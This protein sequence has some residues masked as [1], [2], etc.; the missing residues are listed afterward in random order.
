MKSWRR[1]VTLAERK[2]LSPAYIRAPPIPAAP[3]GHAGEIKCVG[4]SSVAPG[5]QGE[6]KLWEGLVWWN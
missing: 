4:G 6:I 2:V 3:G 1:R 5:G